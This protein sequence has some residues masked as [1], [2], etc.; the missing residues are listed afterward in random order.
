MARNL[1]A[2]TVTAIE[3]G[4][5]QPFIAVSIET[6]GGTFRAWTG[7][8]DIIIDSNTYLGAGDLAGISTITEASDLSANGV[9]LSLSG[10]PPANISLA[11]GQIQ[12]GREANVLLGFFDN[13]T[14]S[15]VVDPYLLFTGITDIPIITDNGQTATISIQCENKL[16]RLTKSNIRRY[17]PEDQE[18]DFPA[19]KGFD[20]VAALQD[21]T[22]E[23]GAR[24]NDEANLDIET[25]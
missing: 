10:V 6:S 20:F 5:V 19:D 18:R 8:G 4:T 14:G 17:T 24:D 1:T 7:Y 16:I 2:A 21:K 23:F 12:Q 11:L 3:E 15:V 25:Q 13:A 22:I 9:S